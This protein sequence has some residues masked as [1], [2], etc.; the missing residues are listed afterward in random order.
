MLSCVRACA[1]ARV[2]ACARACVRAGTCG[3]ASIPAQQRANARRAF[4]FA[5][6]RVVCVLARVCARIEACKR[7]CAV[8]LLVLGFAYAATS[9]LW[10]PK[11]CATRA[12]RP[13]CAYLCVASVTACRAVENEGEEKKCGP[14][15]PRAAEQAGR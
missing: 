9:P 1:R 7:V 11:T 15:V 4:A 2:H 13:S 10:K 5:Y 8:Y 3:T 14:V 12:T 6:E